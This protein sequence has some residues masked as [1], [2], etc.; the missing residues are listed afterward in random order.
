MK[1]GNY[2]SHLYRRGEVIKRLPPVTFFPLSFPALEMIESSF[3]SKLGKA[4]PI[5]PI[6]WFREGIARA[7]EVI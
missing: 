1:D 6:L 4:K 3:V 7:G 5:Y 2:G